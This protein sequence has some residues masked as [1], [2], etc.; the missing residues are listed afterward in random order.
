[1]DNTQQK[2]IDISLESDNFEIISYMDDQDNYNRV[3]KLSDI[4]LEDIIRTDEN[5]I[6]IY[7][8]EV[9]RPIRTSREHN[10]VFLDDI[11]S[12]PSE[13]TVILKAP[14]VFTWP[15]MIAA[16]TVILNLIITLAAY[17][18]TQNNFNDNVRKDVDKLSEDY[19]GVL[20]STYTKKEIDLQIEN[21]KLDNKRQDEVIQMN[22]ELIQREVKSNGNPY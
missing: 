22:K 17:Y 19:E 20:T 10:R 13:G 18:Y 6:Y 3:E 5:Y 14:T 16:G 8:T 21:I 1:M 11:E 12:D 9:D 4:A 2:E 7:D 15:T